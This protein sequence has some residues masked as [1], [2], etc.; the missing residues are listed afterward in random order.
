MNYKGKELKEF[1]SDKPVSFDP[2]KEVLVWTS[3]TFMKK[4]EHNACDKSIVV[5]KWSDTEWHKPTIDY[6]G[7]L[8]K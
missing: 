5:R 1:K 2:P 3:H 8:V 6:M 4:D 7:L